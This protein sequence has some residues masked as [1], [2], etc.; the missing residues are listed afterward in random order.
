[1]TSATEKIFLR[2][3]NKVSKAIDGGGSTNFTIATIEQIDAI[4]NEQ[5]SIS[6]G[7]N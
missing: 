4:F 5:S 1:M 7:L 2:F 6:S 3:M